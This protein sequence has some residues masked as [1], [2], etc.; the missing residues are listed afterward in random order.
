MLKQTN[1]A[2]DGLISDDHYLFCPAAGAAVGIAGV[3]RTAGVTGKTGA[4]GTAGVIATAGLD[5]A[6]AADGVDIVVCGRGVTFF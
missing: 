3:T 1:V 5:A 6:G 4:T 2:L